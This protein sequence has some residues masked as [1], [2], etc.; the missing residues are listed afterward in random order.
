MGFLRREYW[1]GLPFPSPNRLATW[2][3]EHQV[4]THWKRLWCYKRLR[5]GAEGVTEDVMVGRHHRLNGHE[6][7]QIPGNSEEQ[8]SLVCCSPLGHKE[9]DVTEWLNTATLILIILIVAIIILISILLSPQNA[10]SRSYSMDDYESL[11]F[12]HTVANFHYVC[13]CRT[14]HWFC[15]R[16]SRILEWV[17]ISFSRES[18]QPRD[19]AHVSC[20]GRQVLC[21]WATREVQR[22]AST[23]DL[24]TF[25]YLLLSFHPH[26]HACVNSKCQCS[27]TVIQHRFCHWL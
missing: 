10:Y 11:F 13:C 20:I 26:K 7:E 19:R 5:A 9:S 25:T 15:L 16:N 14:T 23:S 24:S 1:G 12:I 27:F 22:N 4:K 3:K 2:C 8:G 18:S 21:Q 17:A 6:F